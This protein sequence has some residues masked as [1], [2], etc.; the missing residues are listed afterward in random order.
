MLQRGLTANG[1]FV[2][3]FI[4]VLIAAILNYQ[5]I[6]EIINKNMI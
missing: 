6:N 4:L 2:V 1:L 3:L 5:D